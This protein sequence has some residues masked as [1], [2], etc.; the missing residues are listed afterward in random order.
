MV[1]DVILF[2]RIM[3]CRVKNKKNKNGEIFIKIIEK[4]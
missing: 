3:L 4:Q 1:L 2:I